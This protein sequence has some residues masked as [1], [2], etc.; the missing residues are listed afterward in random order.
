[1]RK[2]LFSFIAFLMLLFTPAA[3]AQHGGHA[4]GGSHGGG[5]HQ[6]SQPHNGGQRGGGERQ[7]HNEQRGERRGGGERHEQR[8]EARGEARGRSEAREHFN[9]G[10]F[11]HEYFRGHWGEGN[12]FY[13]GRCEWFGGPRFGVGSWFGFGGGYWSIVEPIP[14][15][16]YDDEVYVEWVDGYGYVLVDPNYPGVY[17][18]VGVQF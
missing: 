4:G 12:R 3:F 6:A 11:D 14:Y 17:F 18:R 15:W 2:L 13:W 7:A 5:S 9:G 16:W 1:M 10:R 8:G